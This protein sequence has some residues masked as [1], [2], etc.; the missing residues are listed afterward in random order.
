MY[1]FQILIDILSNT[2]IPSDLL[3]V[4]SVKLNFQYLFSYRSAPGQTEEGKKDEE[5]KGR[6]R[7]ERVEFKE[8][9][10]EKKKKTKFPSA[11]ARRRRAWETMRRN[12]NVRSCPSPLG[13][14]LSRDMNLQ[15]NFPE[16]HALLAVCRERNMLIKIKIDRDTRY[17][18]IVYMRSFKNFL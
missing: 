14:P 7:R 18:L 16:L 6:E 2:I 10:K 15:V 9:G 3:T 8:R 13:P 17:P 4:D 12:Y 5:F 1:K 11:T